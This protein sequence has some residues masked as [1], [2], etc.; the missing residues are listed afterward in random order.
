MIMCDNSLK[1]LN[2]EVNNEAKIID[3]R[4]TLNKLIINTNLYMQNQFCSSF[5][6][7]M[8]ANKFLSFL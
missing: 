7:E 5:T 3:E 8:R 4:L 6:L 1:N 2:N